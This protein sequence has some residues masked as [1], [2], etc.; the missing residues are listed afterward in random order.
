[1]D[2][3][4]PQRHDDAMVFTLPPHLPPATF[5]YRPVLEL[6]ERYERRDNGDFDEA[7]S[8]NAATYLTRVRLGLDL[9][10]DAA[11]K[12][13]LVYQLSMA[14]M[15]PT[16]GPGADLTG[17]DL[18]EANVSRNAAGATLTIGRQKVNLGSQRLIGALEWA[19]SS[20]SWLGVRLETRDWGLFWGEL[21]SNPV[22][23]AKA[24]IAVATLRSC[25]GETS[26]VY[27]HDAS[28]AQA[29][30]ATFDH[31]YLD[32]FGS[33]RLSA[34][35]AFQWGRKSGR[36][37]EAWAAT[38]RADM[39]LNQRVKVFAEGNVATG[40]GSASQGHAFDN[41]YPTNHLYYGM[42]DLQG[43]SNLRGLSAG[44]EWR[45][46]SRLSLELSLHDFNLYDETDGW[47]GAAGAINRRNGVPYVDPS[48]ASGRHVGSEV[49]LVARFLVDRSTSLEAGFGYFSPGRFVKSFVG[50]PSVN[51]AFGYVQANY[52]F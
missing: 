14:R 35:G 43:W 44:I 33:V 26:L 5:Q 39:A 32:Q 23:N 16:V 24:Q 25:A 49:D 29:S 27:K 36:D 34:E 3:L 6:R 10:L 9:A 41:L 40:G 4:R 50:G 11:S 51:G 15:E 1:M 17:Q 46:D 8:D 52:R 21:E 47:Y 19:N 42:M 12:A 22:P 18:I 48:G 2:R 45:P 37:H 38:V 31:R 20:R 28:T 13:R 7:L 30:L